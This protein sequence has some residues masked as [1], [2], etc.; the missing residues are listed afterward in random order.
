[1]ETQC[2]R[3]VLQDWSGTKADNVVIGQQPIRVLLQLPQQP[4]QLP[5]RHPLRLLQ[6]Q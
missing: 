5:L 1:M 2:C 3:I 6:L 4:P